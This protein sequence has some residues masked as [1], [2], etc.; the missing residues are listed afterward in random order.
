MKT[1]YRISPQE[2]GV[3]NRSGKLIM[4]V[5]DE[6]DTVLALKIHLENSG[7]RVHTYTSPEKAL[8]E[9][10][11]HLY[12]LILLDVKMPNMN[13]FQLYQ[14]LRVI[15][16][17]CKACFITGFEA[18]YKSLREFFPKLDVSCFIQKPVSQKK[19]LEHIARELN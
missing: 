5:Y 1:Y 17:N 15:D 2:S 16:D 6:K 8:S 14:K 4:I 3:G 13:G 9:F 7:Y 12:D 10:K 18:Y 19:L 11:P